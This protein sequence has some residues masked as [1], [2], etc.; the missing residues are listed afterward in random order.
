MNFESLLQALDDEKHAVLQRAV[1][2]GKWPDGRQL[3]EEEKSTALRVL[4]A[5]DA[6]NKPEDQRIGYIP[7]KADPCAPRNDDS[8]SDEVVSST[9]DTISGDGVIA[10]DR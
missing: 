10:R 7:P 2:L 6:K 3:S 8:H 1:E 9:P 5:Y 4:I